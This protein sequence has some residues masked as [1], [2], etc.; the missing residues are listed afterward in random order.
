MNTPQEKYH[1]DPQYRQ[2]VDFLE[3]LITQAKFTPSEI[4]EICMVACVHYEIKQPFVF[5][6]K[7]E[8]EEA[9]TTLEDFLKER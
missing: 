3:D 8:V 2:L 4:R 9:L 6:I 7:P 5:T 1:N